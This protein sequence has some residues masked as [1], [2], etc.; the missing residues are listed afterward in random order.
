M[1]RF[2]THPAILILAATV[3]SGG[4]GYVIGILVPRYVPAV[5]YAT[6]A[7]VWSTLFFAVGAMGGLQQEFARATT[8]ASPSHDAASGAGRSLVFALLAAVVVIAVLGAASALWQPTAIPGAEPGTAWA[9]VVGVASYVLVAVCVGTLYGLQ[10]WSP[11]AALLALDGVLRLAAVI[12]ALALG[13]DSVALSWA[14]VLPFPLALAIVLPFVVGR[15]RREASVEASYRLL[16]AHSAQLVLASAAT[17]ALVSGVPLLLHLALPGVARGTLAPILL[18]L[19]LT[20][21]PIVIPLLALQSYLVV[22]FRDGG[23]RPANRFALLVLAA[24]LVLAVIAA[25]VG[26]L[27]LRAVFGADYAIGALAIGLIVGSSGEL[28]AMSVLAAAL[29]ARGAHRGNTASWALAIG[30]TVVLLV[31]VHGSVEIRVGL[32]LFGGAALGLVSHLAVLT[33]RSGDSRV[34]T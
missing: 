26:P 22:R 28:A 20:R 15:V 5:D 13:G 27:A 12:V 25:L 32:A 8:S 1:R 14:I 34:P 19:T 21:A 18:A 23:S 11:I 30:A 2:P 7:V 16:A 17:A 24:G 6:F 33:M 3:L 4:C 29:I 31:L 10:A 9:I